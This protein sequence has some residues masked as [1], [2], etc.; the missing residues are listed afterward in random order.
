[1]EHETTKPKSAGSLPRERHPD[2]VTLSPASLNKIA[3][4]LGQVERL[5]PGLS[6]N[7]NDLL[8]WILDVREAEL[9]AQDLKSLASLY[10]DEMRFARWACRQLKEARSRGE[11]ITLKDIVLKNGGEATLAPA[12]RRQRNQDK[13]KDILST[14]ASEISDSTSD[15]EVLI[16]SKIPGI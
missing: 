16:L 1:M 9:S 4:W 12:K 5:A 11:V 3:S 8:N 10:F 14:L 7:R 2:R 6:L 13:S 15:D